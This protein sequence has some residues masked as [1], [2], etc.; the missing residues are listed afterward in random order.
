[1]PKKFNVCPKFVLFNVQKNGCLLWDAGLFSK[2]YFSDVLI[3]LIL[4]LFLIMELYS[5]KIVIV[6][7]V[8]F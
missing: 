6:M 8:W 1:M 5:V 3:S 2:N 7:M 4:F